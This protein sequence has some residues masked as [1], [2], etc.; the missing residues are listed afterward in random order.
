MKKLENLERRFVDL[1]RVQPQLVE[2]E[3]DVV[4]D[5]DE[6]FSKEVSGAA[7]HGDIVGLL[8]ERGLHLLHPI[9]QLC[10]LVDG[11]NR[12]HGGFVRGSEVRGL[13]ACPISTL[14][15]SLRYAVTGHARQY[16]P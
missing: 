11:G 6:I 3:L 4:R 9:D 5:G 8:S 1:R 7:Q 13:C 16:Y 12:R 10:H 2:V 14:V 15:L